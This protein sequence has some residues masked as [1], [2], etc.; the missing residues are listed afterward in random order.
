M[1]VFYLKKMKKKY[2]IK[3][4]SEID[5]IIHNRVSN[6]NR[7]FVIYYKENSFN[8]FRF[9]LSI[10]RK[11]GNAVARNKIKRQIRMI[12]SEITLNNFD[13]VIVIK[14]E[15]TKL[16]YQEIKTNINKLLTKIKETE[17][18]NEK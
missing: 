18:I 17:K 8:H 10:G 9:A 15:A 14:R 12:V 16:K 7:F 5:A 13:F 3:K 6:G 2:T 11:Y 1:V 4:T